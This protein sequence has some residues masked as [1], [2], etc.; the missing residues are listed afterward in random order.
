MTN[1][2]ATVTTTTIN[3]PSGEYLIL[4]SGACGFN[5]LGEITNAPVFTTNLVSTATNANGFV[6]TVSTVTSFTPHQ[7]LVQPINCTNTAFSTGLY[8]GIEKVQFVRA[9]FDSLLGQFFQPV[10]NNY[11][12]TTITNSQ[13]VVQRF[14]R[15]VTVPDILLTAQN[16]VA[17]NLFDGTVTRTAM[18]FDMDNV[19]AGLAGPGTINPRATISYNK[20]GDAFQNGY[21]F[22]GAATNAYFENSQMPVLQWASFDASTNDPV[23]YPNGTSIANLQNQVLIQVTPPPPTLPDG[24]NG[25]AYP[26]QTFTAAGGAFSPP[27]TWALASGSQPMPSGLYFTNSAPGVPN[28]TIAGTP[29]NNPTG[30]FGAPFDFTVQ[31]TDSLG[32]SVNWNYTIT[33]H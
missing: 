16:D 1:A 20:I 31:L 33:I 2:N 29:A 6:D 7:F 15:I 5:I 19:G 13:A 30:P 3:V 25:V 8:E 11:T 26:A 28:D 21:A 32:R 23:L 12:M 27:Y 24:T 10:T 18:P 17:A 9:D 14:Q 4:P 22:S